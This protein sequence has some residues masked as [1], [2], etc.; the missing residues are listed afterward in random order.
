MIV[1]VEN[2]L[3]TCKINVSDHLRIQYITSLEVLQH[4]VLFG[5]E[6]DFENTITNNTR[7]II[8]F[9]HSNY[10]QIF[11]CTQSVLNDVLRFANKFYT[12]IYD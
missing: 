2:A 3:Q 8:E 7:V 9:V 6:R 5:K 4:I 1:S 11:A 12:Y 10:L